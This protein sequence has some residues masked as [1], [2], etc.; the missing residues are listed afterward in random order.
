MLN[1]VVGAY[2]HWALELRLY[3]LEHNFSLLPKQANEYLTAYITLTFALE[4]YFIGGCCLVFLSFLKATALIIC[5]IRP[6]Q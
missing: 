2:S 1:H 3:Y 4:S 5:E 6:R